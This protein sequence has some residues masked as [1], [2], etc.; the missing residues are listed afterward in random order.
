M[1]SFLRYVFIVTQKLLD[2]ES[3]FLID[4]VIGLDGAG[5]R[6]NALD[7]LVECTIRTSCHLLLERPVVAFECRVNGS[8]VSRLSKCPA[9]IGVR[10]RRFH[11]VE[12]RV[13]LS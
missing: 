10:N 2:R 12:Y 13:R 8:V 6:F 5:K 11:L 1:L 3:M 4:C 7:D 9:R